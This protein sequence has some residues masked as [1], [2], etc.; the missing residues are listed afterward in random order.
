[1]INDDI[2]GLFAG[3]YNV[4]ATDENGCSVSA[5]ITVDFY[6]PLFGM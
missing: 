4:V 2:D 6:T 3:T 5:D 1:M